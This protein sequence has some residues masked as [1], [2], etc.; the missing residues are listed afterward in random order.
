MLLVACG[1]PVDL[2]AYIFLTIQ[3]EALS[4]ELL[5]L[6]YGLLLTQFLHAMLVPEGADEEKGHPLLP[7]N[8]TTLF[9]SMAQTR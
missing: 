2:A 3:A 5:A 7:I 1:T 8:D 6:S 9:R 4:H